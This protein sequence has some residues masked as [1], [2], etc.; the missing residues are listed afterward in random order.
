M[1]RPKEG[2]RYGGFKG[3]TLGF[4]STIFKSDSVS[5]PGRYKM[6]EEAIKEFAREFDPQPFHLDEEA[7]KKSLF[8]GLAASGWHTAAASMRLIV[9]AGPPF[10]NGTVG[11]GGESK[12][13]RPVRPGDVLHV[14]SEVLALTPSQSRPDRGRVTIR[15]LTINQNGDIVQNLVATIVVPRRALN[16]GPPCVSP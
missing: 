1:A 12:W 6:E 10:A 15:H 3:T 16:C 14:E 4:I 11:A 8:G 5:R 13:P 2:C 9:D 7:A